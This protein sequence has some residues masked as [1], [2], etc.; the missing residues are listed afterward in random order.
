MADTSLTTKG[1]S[2]G[3]S[4]GNGGGK[5]HHNPC[6]KCGKP[7]DPSVLCWPVCQLCNKRHPI[8]RCRLNPV[9]Q[10]QNNNQVRGPQAPLQNQQLMGQPQPHP[11]L[12]GVQQQQW[13]QL[14]QQQ[15]FGGMMAPMP[16]MGMPVG[17]MP[18][19][20]MPFGGMMG[21]MGGGMMG[22]PAPIYNYT[23]QGGHQNFSQAAPPTKPGWKGNNKGGKKGGAT[24]PSITGPVGGAGVTKP[25]PR[26]RRRRQNNKPTGDGDKAGGE[27]AE[28]EEA[29]KTAAKK[30]E[31]DDACPSVTEHADEVVNRFTAMGVEDVVERLIREAGTFPEG[32]SFNH[33][34]IRAAANQIANQPV[35][36]GVFVRVAYRLNISVMRAV[37]GFQ[38]NK[39][40]LLKEELD[41]LN[42]SKK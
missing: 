40:G 33:D 26:N 19:G 41:I 11:F 17:G 5:R 42:K 30:E 25:K 1:G 15:M 24:A 9:A 38:N 6:D 23:I 32:E 28:K 20:G 39:I 4:G 34:A 36:L 10:G 16:Q 22:S 31:M 13:L 29:E 8:G 12:T 37:L 35:T 7:H 27:E 2:V 14:Q 18:F 3:G 21:M